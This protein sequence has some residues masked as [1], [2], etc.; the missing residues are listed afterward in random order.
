MATATKQNAAKVTKSTTKAKAEVAKVA[1]KGEIPYREGSAYWASIEVLRK[2]GAGKFHPLEKV[3]K[4]IPAVM[5]PERWTT[6]R[7]KAGRNENAKGPE[8]RVRQNL[9]VLMRPDYGFPLRKV[10]GQE[11]RK[12]KAA[13]G[14][15]S[16]GLFKFTGEVVEPTAPR[17]VASVATTPQGASKPKAKAKTAQPKAKPPKKATKAKPVA[18]K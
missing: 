4:A 3:I 1:A 12:E 9:E 6:F 17:K 5:G 8:D 10:A 18:A 11:V 14:V 13:D 16:F 15:I 7:D 2:L